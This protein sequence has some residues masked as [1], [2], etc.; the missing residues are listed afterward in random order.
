MTPESAVPAEPRVQHAVA[1]L[2]VGRAMQ[3]CPT[4]QAAAQGILS[5][6]CKFLDWDVGELWIV[7][8]Q[9]G[10]ARWAGLSQ[11]GDLD[12][13]EFERFSSVMSIRPNLGIPGQ[14]WASGG[15]CISDLPNH[16]SFK[17]GSLL[18]DVGLRTVVGFPLQYGSATLGMVLLFS[19]QPREAHGEYVGILT[20][21]GRQIGKYYGSE[22]SVQRSDSFFSLLVERSPDVVFV[23]DLDGTVRYVNQ[24]AQ[25]YG[26]AERRQRIGSSAFDLIHPDDRATV[27][28]ALRAA[29]G[30]PGTVLSLRGRGRHI[31]GSWGRYHVRFTAVSDGSSAPFILGTVRPIEDDGRANGSA[32]PSSVV[33]AKFRLTRDEL[34]TLELITQGLS[35]KRICEILCV[36]Q[37]TIKSRVSAIIRKLGAT[38]RAGAVWLAA[39]HGLI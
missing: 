23:L 7:D 33:V 12:L 19:R 5:T 20:D 27:F 2:E 31:D 37:D 36:S 16:A 10:V 22:L 14:V 34:L 3:G 4:L 6:L 17:R 30:K 35:N 18:R 8:R 38:N 28:D 13:G 11:V 15:V 25:Q 9:A 29:V 1:K 39:K 21:I 24:V 26:G 32:A